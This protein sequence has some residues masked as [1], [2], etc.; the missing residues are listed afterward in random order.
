MS[1]KDLFVGFEATWFPKTSLP[2]MAL[3]E[4]AYCRSVSAGERVSL[5]LRHALFEEGRDIAAADVLADI[6]GA[7]DVPQPGADDRAAILTD[8]HE[9]RR[10]GVLGSPHFFIGGEGFFC[11]ALT[12]TRVGGRLHIVS[13][14][15]GFRTFLAQAFPAA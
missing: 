15:A 2:A 13:D 3:A 10:R 8:W 12:I 4:A 14:H 7:N 11:P 9:G 1:R 6:A 5:A